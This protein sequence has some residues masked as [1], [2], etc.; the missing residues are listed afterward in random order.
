MRDD[1]SRH[2]GGGRRGRGITLADVAQAAGVSKTTVSNAY[3]RPDQLS[4]PLRQRVLEVAARIGYMGPDPIAVTFSRRRAGAIGLVFDDPLTF[5][6]TDPAEVL[7]VTGIGE[8][9]E[10]AG[11]GLVLIPLGP[12]DDLIRHTLVD[13]F[14]C[15]CD[16]DGDRRVD[17]AIG[18]E[19]PVVVVDGPA[20]PGTGHVGVR[21]REGA[22]AAARHLLE[23]GHRQLAVLTAPLN[24]DGYTGPADLARQQGARYYVSKERLLGY[25]AEAEAAG[26]DW[27][28]VPVLEAS[29]YGRQAGH[30]AVARL[31]DS[32]DRPTALLAASDELALGALRAAAE[33]GIAVPEQLSIIGFDDAPPAAWSTP[34][35]TTIRQPHRHK[36]QVATEQLLGLRPIQDLTYP[37]ELVVRSSTARPPIR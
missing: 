20:R 37:T 23:L 9:C 2:T 21:D 36:G 12:H 1:K 25:R 29:P 31:L 13:G 18:R 15:H 30:Q 17:A 35:L 4:A 22:A 34:T 32:S 28:E 24:P 26:L 14:I 11:V 5:A 16:I 8:V 27:E 33:R 7:F 6:L 19:L 10:R 3:N